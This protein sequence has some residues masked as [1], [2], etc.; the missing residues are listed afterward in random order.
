MLQPAVKK[1]NFPAHHLHRTQTRPNIPP[2]AQTSVPLHS[3]VGVC[4]CACAVLVRGAGRAH[5]GGAACA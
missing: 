3:P 5:L 1:G 4:A 2:D